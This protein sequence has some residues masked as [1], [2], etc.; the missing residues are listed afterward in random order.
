MGFTEFYKIYFSRL[1]SFAQIYLSTDDA[2]DVVQDVMASLLEK[3]NSSVFIGDMK[4][5]VYTSVK[6][7]CLDI[8]KHET[9][10]HEYCRRTLMAMRASLEMELQ[11]NQSPV[12]MVLEY[13]EAEQ[14]VC[15]AIDE[16]PH[17]CREVF[18]MSRVEGM[19]YKDIADRMSIS[20]NTV[21]CQMTIALKKLRSRM[22]VS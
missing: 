7:R 22:N 6:N 15:Q 4:S 1:V 18:L 9:Y 10:K 8:L 21:E 12:S 5:Y 19:R 11:S 16:L 17:R 2:M 20:Q 13:K 3:Q 14:R